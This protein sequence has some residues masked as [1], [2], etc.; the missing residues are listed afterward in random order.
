MQE[1]TLKACPKCI[2]N[3]FDSHAKF[4]YVKMMLQTLILTRIE[5]SLGDPEMIAWTIIHARRL[6]MDVKFI[7]KRGYSVWRR[8]WGFITILKRN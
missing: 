2:C 4:A 5:C 7:Q 3:L 6:L 1:S 8:W